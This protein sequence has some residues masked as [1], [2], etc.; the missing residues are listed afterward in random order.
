MVTRIALRALVAWC[1][2][3]LLAV[4]N[5]VLRETFLVP[6]LGKSAGF[7]VSGLVLACLILVVA[8]LLLPWIG[9]HGRTQLV[10][11]GCGWLV[12]TLAFEFSFGLLRGL[13]MDA[14]LAAYTFEDGNLWPVVLLVL[15]ASPWIAGKLRGRA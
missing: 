8:V 1:A 9:V 5:G 6:S 7:L 2:I 11:L 3:L 13:P 15:V 14:I 4:G 12:L 10:A